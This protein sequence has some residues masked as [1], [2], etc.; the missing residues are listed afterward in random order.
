M[1][2]QENK[3]ESG[4]RKAAIRMRRTMVVP[5]RAGSG[6][7]RVPRRGRPDPA[8]RRWQSERAL[9]AG[10][11]HRGPPARPSVSGLRIYRRARLYV[12][13]PKVLDPESRPSVDSIP[14]CTSSLP[15]SLLCVSLPCLV[16]FTFRSRSLL[17]SRA[18]LSQRE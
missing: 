18:K 6:R 14:S 1:G 17:S 9:A 13:R 15:L 3:L 10:C 2:H 5:G 12:S 16:K 7:A 4:R 8:R 11:S